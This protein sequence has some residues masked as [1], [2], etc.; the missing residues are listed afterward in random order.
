MIEVSE[1][2]LSHWAELREWGSSSELR[3][4]WLALLVKHVCLAQANPYGFLANHEVAQWV[5]GEI[6][7]ESN[8]LKFKI[9]FIGLLA[10]V[11]QRKEENN[12]ALR[13]VDVILCRK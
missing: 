6:N 9:K 13:C 12:E 10:F 7:S 3:K 8:S 4:S 2:V 11:I 5:F 1:G